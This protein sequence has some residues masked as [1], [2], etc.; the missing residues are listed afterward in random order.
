MV[1]KGSKY[2]NKYG[3][4]SVTSIDVDKGS[5]IVNL[6]GSRGSIATD[7]QELKKYYKKIK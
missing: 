5:R 1:K 7:E 6:R 3:E 2:S 4:W